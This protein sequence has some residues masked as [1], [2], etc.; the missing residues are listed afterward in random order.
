MTI[1]ASTGLI[2]WQNN[3]WDWTEKLDVTV[4]VRDELGGTDTFMNW[5]SPMTVR[6]S[7]TDLGVTSGDRK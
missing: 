3:D 5:G 2:T 6:G 4:K 1:D 7:A